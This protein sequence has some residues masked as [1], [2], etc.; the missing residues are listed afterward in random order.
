VDEK[1]KSR[2][3]AQAGPVR[4][5][6]RK[7]LPGVLVIEPHP[8][9]RIGICRLIERAPDLVLSGSGANLE[10]ALSAVNGSKIDLIVVEPLTDPG[11]GRELINAIRRAVP[12]ARI[13]ALSA[14]SESGYVRCI[15]DAGTSGF[16]TKSLPND[17]LLEAFHQVLASN[18]VVAGAS[19][20]E[21]DGG[22]D[23]SE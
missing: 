22:R 15:I 12:G 9:T 5:E 10:E 16:V 2:S 7:N 17:R 1:T 19:D 21:Q 23:P 20:L 11:G 6:E 14:R 18:N 4:Q 8:I 13:L 3:P